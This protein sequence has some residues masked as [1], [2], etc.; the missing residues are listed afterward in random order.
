MTDGMVH[1]TAGDLRIKVSGT[2]HEVEER[3]AELQEEGSWSMVIERLRQA[4]EAALEAAAEAI[5]KAGLP[6][7]GAAFRQLLQGSGIDR[8]PDQVL[9]AIHYLRSV[10]GLHD[11]PPRVIARLFEDAGL[12]GPGNISLY[13]NRLRERGLLEI[14]EDGDGRNRFAVLTPAGREHLDEKTG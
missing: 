11:S 7:R 4:R 8:R 10:E 2:M 13:L 3:I 9:A 14:P 1:I 5:G 6:E 12:E